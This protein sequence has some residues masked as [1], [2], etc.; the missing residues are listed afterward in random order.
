[1]SRLILRLVLAILVVVA[2][3]FFIARW[4][5]EQAGQRFFEEV[6]PRITE[7]IAT[8]RKR[9]RGVSQQAFK[10]ELDK[11]GRELGYKVTVLPRRS[12]LI[13]PRV[14]RQLHSGRPF[15]ISGRR[16]RHK[17]FVPL[18]QGRGLARLEPPAY[19][20]LFPIGV[21]G[22]TILA[23]TTLTAFLLAF[24][25][26]RRLGR[27]E[28][29]AQRISEGELQAR[30]EVSSRDAFG[31]LA[32][33]FNRMA[34][35]VQEL[36]QS[37]RQLIRAVSHELRTPLSRLRFDL[38]MLAQSSDPAKQAERAASMEEDLDELEQL[39]QEL[40]TY[41][42]AGDRA[43]ELN[44]EPVQSGPLIRELLPWLTKHT[45]GAAVSVTLDPEADEGLPALDADPVHLRRAVKNLLENAARHAEARVV[46]RREVQG[47]LLVISVCDDG[48]G[49]PADQRQRV[50]EPFA[51]LDDSRSRG[52][53]GVGLGLAIVTE[54]A[55]AHGG[56]LKVG[57]APEGGAAFALGWP[58]TLM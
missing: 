26:V 54:I 25:M 30:A 11:V 16:G 57:E 50:L 24:P 21:V 22:G 4:G 47:G 23:V 55:R 37:Q 36:L 34:D 29:A 8:A 9:L 35:R 5:F 51:R 32:R 48:P 12:P 46:V 42:K 13:P 39:I 3:S 43:L 20:G 31:S 28:R 10:Q 17:V 44:R 33:R 41:I 56:D 1:M 45:R 6:V 14:H 18:G 2:A 15:A 49:I 19:S 38:E 27:L 40:L 53:G 58:V 52:S 7:D